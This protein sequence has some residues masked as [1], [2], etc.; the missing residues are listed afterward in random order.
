MKSTLTRSL[1]AGA[2][3]LALT[4]PALAADKGDWAFSLGA[5]SVDPASNNG[6]LA[7]G[8][9]K[10]DVGSNWRPTVTAEYFLGPNVGFEVLASLPFQHD[11]FLNGV[12]AGSTKQLPPT[13]SL[14][15]HFA[16]D[17]VSP[18]VG[19]GVN[20]TLF[21]GEDTTGPL[22]GTKTSLGNSWGLA[23]HAGVD[24]KIADNQAFRIDARWIDIDTDVKVNGTDVGT[25]KIDPMVYGVAY[26]WTF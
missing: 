23:A 16:G 13:F 10:A 6:S 8:A 22:A 24:F 19:I 25:V 12:K 26:V 5:H 17:K 18:F 11:I 9:L 1:F 7:G 4:V 2:L 20:Y 14:Q 21:F 3:A 15:Y